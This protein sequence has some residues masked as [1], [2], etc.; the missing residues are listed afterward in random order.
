MGVQ[1]L[2]KGENQW[3]HGAACDVR[4]SGSRPADWLV[5]CGRCLQ[6]PLSSCPWPMRQCLWLNLAV[7]IAASFGRTGQRPRTG[8]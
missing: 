1:L 4:G 7:D 6:L 8:R 5:E 2:E 3:A